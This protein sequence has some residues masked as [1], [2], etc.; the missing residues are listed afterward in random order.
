M[1][2][3]ESKSHDGPWVVPATRDELLKEYE[4]WGSDVLKIL[5]CIQNPSKWMIHVVNPPLQTYVKG[6]VALLG[7][8]VSNCT[9]VLG[10]HSPYFY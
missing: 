8:A 9:E 1:G 5:G 7:D 3:G 2:I 6:R 10:S 4:G